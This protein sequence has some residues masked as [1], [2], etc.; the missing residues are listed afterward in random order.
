MKNFCLFVHVERNSIYR[1]KGASLYVDTSTDRYYMHNHDFTHRTIFH[2]FFTQTA[3][4]RTT[5]LSHK[6]H[7]CIVWNVTIFSHI[8]IFF[9]HFS[10]LFHTWH[11]FSLNFHTNSSCQELKLFTHFSHNFHTMMCENWPFSHVSF[12][13]I[14]HTFFSHMVYYFHTNGSCRDF[15]TFTCSSH[16]FHTYWYVKRDHLSTHYFHTYSCETCV[17]IFTCVSH[18]FHTHFTQMLLVLYIT[19]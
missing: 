16:I 7:M 11:D 17:K 1:R 5:R 9:T 13:H 2:T 18:R 10:Y 12:S 14:F 15:K 8:F 6:F 4:A 19:S 3:L